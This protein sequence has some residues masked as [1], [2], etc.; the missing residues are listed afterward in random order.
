VFF[1]K[2]KEKYSSYIVD[3]LLYKSPKWKE[4]KKLKRL[5]LF[6]FY[7]SF[8][9]LSFKFIDNSNIKDAFAKI[10]FIQPPKGVGKGMET[11][12]KNN[13]ILT[14]NAL[15]L[16]YYT[17]ITGNETIANLAVEYTKMYNIDTNLFL[18]IMRVE[19]AFNPRAIN[20]NKN[21]SID[22]GLC[23]L[24]NKTFSNLT[25]KDFYNIETNIKYG[26]S[27]LDW[28]LKKSQKNT[29]KALAFYNA[30]IGAVTKKKVGEHTLDY[31]NKVLT[32]KREF[33]AGLNNF[34]VENS[35]LIEK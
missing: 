16:K 22:R 23:Q 12:G 27:F 8:A 9:L 7:L 28:C 20:H 33:D 5:F 3:H 14:T 32:R 2:K 21:G 1:N 10:E 31:I 35:D 29:V 15:K 34:L 18:A 30:G 11:E 25:V 4:I 24:N 26:T 17:Y 13:E 6:S 19:S